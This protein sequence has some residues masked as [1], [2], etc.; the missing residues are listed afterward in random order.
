MSIEVDNANFRIMRQHCHQ[1]QRP[2]DYCC[3]GIQP[4]S[5]TQSLFEIAHDWNVNYLTAEQM[6]RES[7]AWQVGF[8]NKFLEHHDYVYLTIC[9]DVFAECYAPGVS[10][11]QALGLNPWQSLPLLKY[12][13]QTGKVVSID[14]AELSP[15]LDPE[16]KTS[17]LAAVIIAELLNLNY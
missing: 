3:L 12:I 2:F 16:Q 13:V 17:R 5:N 9:L 15:P 7:H 6:N 4:C 8:V 1:Y 10:A 11:P 14:I